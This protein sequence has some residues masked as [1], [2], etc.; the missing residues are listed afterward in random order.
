M[1]NYWSFIESYYPNYHSCDLILLSDIL[2]RKLE[3]QEIDPEDEKNIK[4]WNVK[5]ELL[6]LDKTIMQKAMDHYFEIVYPKVV[7]KKT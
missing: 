2:A 7:F 4:D 5:A 3:N 6:Q 1:T